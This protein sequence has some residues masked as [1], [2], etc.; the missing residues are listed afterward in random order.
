M[1]YYNQPF[2]VPNISEEISISDFR[3]EL[4]ESAL[5]DDEAEENTFIDN[6]NVIMD[7]MDRNKEI[8]MLFQRDHQMKN[9]SNV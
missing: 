1:S 9:Y 7:E 3:E 8:L 6:G 4:L 5:E 2:E